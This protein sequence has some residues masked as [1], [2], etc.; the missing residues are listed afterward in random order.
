MKTVENPEQEYIQMKA[1]LDALKKLVSE[2]MKLN[3]SAIRRTMQQKA[4]EIDRFALRI[5]ILSLVNMFII[6]SFFHRFYHVSSV[7][8]VATELM[9]LFCIIATFLMH[10]PVRHLDFA[11]GNLL[12]VAERMSRFKRQYIRWPRIGLP[13]VILWLGWLMYEIYIG[14]GYERPVFFFLCAGLLCG[15]A[16][17]GTVG[18]HFNRRMVCKAD[19]I[20]MEA[21][22][23]NRL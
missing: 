18:L 12:E 10:N 14:M 17:G 21:E 22:Q 13:M 16:V 1:E 23:L 8:I 7:F 6:P 5:M 20:L 3:E 19:E 11:R 9:M 4:G 15:A 2:N